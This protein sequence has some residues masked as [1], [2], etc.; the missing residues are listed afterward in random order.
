MDDTSDCSLQRLT[1]GVIDVCWVTHRC[2]CRSHECSV[3]SEHGDGGHVLPLGCAS[4]SAKQGAG[5][6]LLQTPPA[7]TE[8]PALLC[9]PTALSSSTTTNVQPVLTNV[10]FPPSRASGCGPL[11]SGWGFT[12]P[13]A[14]D[15]GSPSCLLRILVSV[16]VRAALRLAPE[17]PLRGRCSGASSLESGLTLT[18]TFCRI[19]QGSRL[20][21]RRCLSGKGTFQS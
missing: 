13:F 1:N 21:L 10:P 11:R 8:V 16:A 18:W 20:R 3:R 7:R 15:R 5:T 19:P 6:G 2:R 14:K 17:A 12:S 4:P 9:V